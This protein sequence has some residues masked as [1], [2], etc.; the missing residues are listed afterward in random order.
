MQKENAIL[1]ESNAKL[2]DSAYNVERERQFVATENALKVQ[3]AQLEATLKADLTDKK[4]L[5]DALEVERKNLAQT[6]VELQDLQSKYFTVTTLVYLIQDPGRLL[7]LRKN[8]YQVDL[9]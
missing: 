5:S 8:S 7:N 2:L 1:R 4:V 9:I 3:V 6:E